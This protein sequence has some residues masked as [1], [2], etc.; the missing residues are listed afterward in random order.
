MI[1][2]RTAG[3]DPPGGRGPVAG[4][5]GRPAIHHFLINNSVT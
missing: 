2:D 1:P 3:D 5:R 4:R